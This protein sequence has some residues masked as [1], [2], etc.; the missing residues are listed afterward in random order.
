[1]PER[2]SGSKIFAGTRPRTTTPLSTTVN[3]PNIFQLITLTAGGGLGA[4]PFFTFSSVY[5]LT[6]CIGGSG[7]ELLTPLDSP[8]AITEFPEVEE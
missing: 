7:I 6:Y 4:R 1:L 3:L 2:R 8:V 5:K